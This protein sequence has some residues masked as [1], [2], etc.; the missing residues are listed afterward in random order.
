MLNTCFKD[1]GAGRG[2]WIFRKGAKVGAEF[3]S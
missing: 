2:L 3:L 1:I